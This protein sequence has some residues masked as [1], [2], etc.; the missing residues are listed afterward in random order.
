VSNDELYDSGVL[1]ENRSI[2]KQLK[3]ITRVY[4]YEKLDWLLPLTKSGALAL[5]VVLHWLCWRVRLQAGFCTLK[6]PKSVDIKAQVLWRVYQ[7][8]PFGIVCESLETCRVGD[9][10]EGWKEAIMVI[11][12]SKS[13]T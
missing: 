7:G 6:F 4:I 1:R 10:N 3:L 12:D 9:L 5:S 13:C 8:V 2:T 11:A